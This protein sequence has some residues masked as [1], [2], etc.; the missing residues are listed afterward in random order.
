M[1]EE[2]YA[3]NIDRLP[4]QMTVRLFKRI[5]PGYIAVPL[6]ISFRVKYWLGMAPLPR[7]ATG[8]VGSGEIVAFEQLPPR[9]V[10]QWAPLLEQFNDL[11]CEP[12]V[13]NIPATIGARES[14]SA[15]LLDPAGTTFA[16]LQWMRM[17][18]KG[19]VE[20]S[21]V[22]LNSFGPSDPEIMTGMVEEE[23]VMIAD[24]L[25]LDFVDQKVVSKKV[26]LQGVY[27]MH[28]E[29]IRGRGVSAFSADAATA[30]YLR[31]SQRRFEWVLQQGFMRRL[32]ERE[33]AAIKKLRL[34]E[35]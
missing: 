1:S 35:S 14:A 11:G 21:S 20:Q 4:F 2:Y 27:E 19:I 6:A 26:G 15:L 31:R 24:V 3:E 16:T 18:G 12:L 17:E 28:Q 32:S 25:R 33:I 23:A 10:A 34:P 5:L 8:P 29:R 13:Y 30:E 9:A 7:Y 22:E